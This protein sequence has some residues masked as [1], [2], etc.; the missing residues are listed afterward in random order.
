VGAGFEGRLQLVLADGD[1]VRSILFG[2][3]LSSPLTKRDRVDELIEVINAEADRR[4]GI[5]RDTS[6]AYEMESLIGSFDAPTTVG[7]PKPGAIRVQSLGLLNLAA[8]AAV[9]TLA[10]ALAA[11]FL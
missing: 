7:A 4:S 3:T 1:Q 6:A 11:A 10:C 9:W 2:P 8:Y 5:K